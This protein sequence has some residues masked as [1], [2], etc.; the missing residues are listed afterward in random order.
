MN[1]FWKNF[2][3]VII[4][5]IFTTLIFYGLAFLALKFGWTNV[6]GT[7]DKDNSSYQEI[8]PTKPAINKTLIKPQPNSPLENLCK[9][10]IIETKYSKNSQQL[11]LAY[12]ETHSNNLLT[13]MIFVFNLQNNDPALKKDLEGCDTKLKQIGKLI[14]GNETVKIDNSQNIYAWAN[15]A[16]WQII[17]EALAKEQDTITKAAAA[18][19][20]EPRVLAVPIVVEQLRL[21]FTQREYFEKFFKPFKILGVTNQMA[22]GVMSIKEK[23]A[24]QIENNLKD[25]KSPYYLG[26]KYENLLDFNSQNTAKER[27]DRLTNQKDQY[28]SYLYGALYIKE[29]ETQWEKAGFPISDRPEIIATLY[30]LGFEH[31]E[32]KNNPQIGGSTLSIGN[33]EYTFGG[34]GSQFYYSGEIQNLFPYKVQEVLSAN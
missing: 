4:V 15:T 26:K 28:Y 12:N 32:P 34:L 25:K 5:I 22:M 17:V 3:S 8:V 30:N 33:E 20:I 14:L 24:I 29:I 2:W 7:I 1:K 11:E 21:Y 31:S 10:K 13:K 6:G 16:E 27:Y 9:L 19:D 23:T 18:A